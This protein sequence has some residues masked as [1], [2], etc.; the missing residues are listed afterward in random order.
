VRVVVVGNIAHVVIDGPGSVH[1]L[2]VGDF[3]EN[4]VK[5][6]FHLLGRVGIVDSPDHH[7]HEAYLAISDPTRLVLE[8]ALGEDGRLAEFT[9]SVH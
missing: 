9:L 7:R 4:L 1:E 3:G 2:F 5:V 6:A 8:V